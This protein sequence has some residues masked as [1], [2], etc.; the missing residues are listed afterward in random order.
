MIEV[1]KGTEVAPARLRLPF[2]KDTTVDLSDSYVPGPYFTYPDP[3]DWNDE[4]TFKA[5]RNVT[6]LFDSLV[7]H[8]GKDYKDPK[9]R[10]SGRSFRGSNEARVTALSE[11]L[12]GDARRWLT[13]SGESGSRLVGVA[14]ALLIAL[15]RNELLMQATWTPKRL[16][17]A[18][19]EG[20]LS[21]HIAALQ[22]LGPLFQEG[23][24]WK[25]FVG[26]NEHQIKILGLILGHA[27]VNEK[28]SG[29]CSEKRSLGKRMVA[30]IN[31][32]KTAD[33]KE[34]KIWKALEAK[35]EALREPESEGCFVGIAKRPTCV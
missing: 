30:E 22:Q 19:S 23:A 34:E 16:N 18:D 13:T 29:C 1:V 27:R 7:P 14:Q 10:T 28:G 21:K 9:D 35:I 8:R 12:L 32:G 25:D 4:A 33:Y 20:E 11:E 6:V 17:L 5:P 31:Q 15:S 3:V 26:K 24:S 2:E